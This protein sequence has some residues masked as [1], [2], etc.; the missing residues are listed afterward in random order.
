MART[1]RN[2]SYTQLKWYWHFIRMNAYS[3][4]QQDILNM[5]VT[6]SY[7]FTSYSVQ[8]TIYMEPRGIWDIAKSSCCQAAYPKFT[9][10][11]IRPSSLVWSV[12]CFQTGYIKDLVHQASQFF[13]SSVIVCRS[14]QD[15]WKNL[16]TLLQL[17]QHLSSSSTGS[18][19]HPCFIETA[20]K[21]RAFSCSR[22]MGGF[23]A[24]LSQGS[25]STMA[26]LGLRLDDRWCHDAMMTSHDGV[27]MG[28][29]GKMTDFHPASRLK[30]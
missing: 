30:L 27:A 17:I 26:R 4:W 8:Y 9:P 2:F 11:L 20:S 22:K 18:T 15:I 24:S 21:V 29:W 12:R 23:W 3:S 19:V 6:S 13:H 16:E 7:I 1:I 25:G 28:Q 10:L 14:A 5:N